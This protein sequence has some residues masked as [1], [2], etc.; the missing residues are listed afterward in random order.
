[1]PP[2][3]LL[4]EKPACPIPRQTLRALF[5]FPWKM[6]VKAALPIPPGKRWIIDSAADQ[7]PEPGRQPRAGDLFR[8]H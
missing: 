1:M 4:S 2:P 8:A 7:H 6:A 3:L 5:R